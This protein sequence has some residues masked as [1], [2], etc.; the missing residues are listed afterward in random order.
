MVGRQKEYYNL[1]RALYEVT[2][3]GQNIFYIYLKIAVY[4]TYIACLQDLG[5]ARWL[6]LTIIG[7]ES[8]RVIWLF[9]LIAGNW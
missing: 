9:V 3:S 4:I 2:S 6:I 8:I 7:P 5:M 1:L